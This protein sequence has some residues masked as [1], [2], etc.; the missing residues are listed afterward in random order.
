MTSI[1]IQTVIST[2]ADGRTRDLRYR[3]R[4]FI[5][6]HKWITSHRIDIETA[7]CKDDNLSKLEAQLMVSLTLRELR[8]QYEELDL[9]KTLD[10]EYSVKN[11][12]NNGGGSSSEDLVY[13]LPEAFTFFY[14][15]MCA[16]CTCIAA[17]SC[18][19]I[20]LPT[21]FMH[22]SSVTRQCLIESLDMTA[23]GV[24]STRPPSEILNRCLVIDQIGVLPSLTGR[25][26]LRSQPQLGT[27]AVID[28]TANLELATKEILCSRTFFSSGGP[29]APSCILVNEY[30]EDDFVRLFREQLSTVNGHVAIEK[31]KD[32]NV[33][34]EMVP[35]RASETIPQELLLNANGFRVIK[36][37]GR[38]Y[39]QVHGSRRANV[40]HLLA[41]SSQD[42]AIDALNKD[43]Q[44][45]LLALYVFAGPRVAK[46]LTQ[47]VRSNVSF[48][49]HIPA[50]LLVGPAAPIDYPVSPIARYRR[51]MM[52]TPSPKFVTR[53]SGELDLQGL[54]RE[55]LKMSQTLYN[56]SLQPLKPTGQPKEGDKNFFAQGMLTGFILLVLPLFTGVVVGTSYIVLKLYRHWR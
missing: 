26:T 17:G 16:M 35:K 47:F 55:G 3:Q 9:K 28:R 14:S 1:E 5:S 45:P 29:Y 36:V 2:A 12:R 42:D 34:N 15:V 10:G 56:D 23:Y 4:Q 49:N 24:T 7:A 41:T 31:R 48:V 40:I 54:V 50:N 44:N 51:H 53:L 21:D 27:V 19:V 25:R 43:D 46:Y 37:L 11:G 20:E 30:V 13:I 18:C 39:L 8:E 22:S 32:T 33:V 6:L 52:E 38:D